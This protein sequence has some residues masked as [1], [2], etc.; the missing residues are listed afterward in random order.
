[1]NGAMC[2]VDFAACV[3]EYEAAVYGDGI[4]VTIDTGAEITLYDTDGDSY[5][6]IGTADELYAFAAAVNSGNITIINGELTAN[7][8]VNANVLNADGSVYTNC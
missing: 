3:G 6:E 7:I 4:T 1:M 8:V 2:A 5:Y